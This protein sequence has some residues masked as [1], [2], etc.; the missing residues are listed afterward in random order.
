[1]AAGLLLGLAAAACSTSD[2]TPDADSTVAPGA[3]ATATATAVPVTT[4]ATMGKV[5]GKLEPEARARLLDRITTTVD[6]WIDDAFPEGPAAD[7]DAATA[8]AAFTPGAATRARS[9]A[10]LLSNADLPADVESVEL[11]NRRLVLDVLAVHGRAAGVTARVTVA[12]VLTG[13]DERR[14][15]VTGSLLLSYGD[16]AWQVFGYDMDRGVVR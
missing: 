16:D 1:M 10:G 2:D 4:V 5:T 13:A 3:S 7:V 15:R 14:E 9:D 11:V 8:F 6:E 12:M